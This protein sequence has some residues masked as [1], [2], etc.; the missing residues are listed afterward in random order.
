MH[1]FSWCSHLFTYGGTFV[2]LLYLLLLGLHLSCV[3]YIASEKFSPEL[4]FIG[5]PCLLLLM[6]PP[7]ILSRAHIWGG[8]GRFFSFLV[9]GVGPPGGCT[10]KGN[11][12]SPACLFCLFWCKVPKIPKNWI[13]RTPLPPRCGWG[14]P[15]RYSHKIPGTKLPLAP[16]PGSPRVALPARG[17]GPLPRCPEERSPAT[18]A[19]DPGGGCGGEVQRGHCPPPGPASARESLP[20]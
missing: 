13:P 12:G 2:Y 17:P 5:F 19:G 1:K 11:C 20:P 15:S 9:P 18:A 7:Y 16:G 8:L 6:S 3:H 14:T 4:V 10:P